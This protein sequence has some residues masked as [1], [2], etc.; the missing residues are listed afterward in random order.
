M[1]NKIL[2]MKEVLVLTGLCRT[3]IYNMMNAGHF[4]KSRAISVRRVGWFESDIKNWFDGLK[5]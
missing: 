4:P 1:T 3:S 2:K 5:N